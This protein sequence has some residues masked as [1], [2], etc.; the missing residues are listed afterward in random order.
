[1]RPIIGI[2]CA[3]FDD[4]EDPTKKKLHLY[5]PYIEAI[6]NNGG[7]PLLL[8]IVE[9]KEIID[10]YLST[11]DGLLLT[12]G[13]GLHPKFQG[14]DPLPDLEEQNPVRHQFDITLVIGALKN[15]LPTVGI[16]RGHQ[17]INAAAGGTLTLS[18]T[19]LTDITHNQAEPRDTATHAINIKQGS[20]LSELLNQDQIMV[21]SFHQQVVA[22]PAPGFQASAWS[23]DG[24]V[25]AMESTNHNFILGLQF[26]PET[27]TQT[28]PV[29]NNIFTRLIAEAAKSK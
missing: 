18:I 15:D 21:N 14:M 29:W 20:L 8:P 3:F 10:Y 7:I 5:K 19:G 6:E 27:L 13:G 11:V 28:D 1:M 17:T 23:Q 26:H 16:C 2:N 12:G 9:D 4:T 24:L 25:E 22:S